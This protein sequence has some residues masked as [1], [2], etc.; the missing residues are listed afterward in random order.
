MTITVVTIQAVV[1]EQFGY[2]I[3]YQKTMKAKRKAMTRLI[4]D[5]YKSYVELSCFFLALEQSN[6]GCIVYSKMVFGNSLN[7]E[8]FQC[9]F[10]VFVPSIKG[11]THYRLVFSIGGTYLY[12]KYKGTLLIA[13]GCDGNNQLFPLAFVIIKGENTNSWSWFFCMY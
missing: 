9:V 2:Q 1:A 6:L 11:F 3:S 13:M 7:E 10:W 5:W 8:S 4:G 12:G